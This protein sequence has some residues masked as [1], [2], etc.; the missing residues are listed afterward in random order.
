MEGNVVYNNYLIYPKKEAH[1]A[2][3]NAYYPK[4]YFPI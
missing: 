1:T 2:F 3:E 4:V